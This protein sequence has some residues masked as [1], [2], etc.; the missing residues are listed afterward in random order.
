MM[1]GSLLLSWSVNSIL[2]LISSFYVS[3]DSY[4]PKCLHFLYLF[5]GQ[6]SFSWL[7]G[8]H[9]EYLSLLVCLLWNQKDILSTHLNSGSRSLLYEPRKR[10]L[11]QAALPFSCHCMMYPFSWPKITQ[12]EQERSSTFLGWSGSYHKDFTADAK[13]TVLGE[14]VSYV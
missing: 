7:K 13:A 14:G 4:D 5:L 6:L 11:V 9:V 8:H 3:V 12:G 2:W 10:A 1:S